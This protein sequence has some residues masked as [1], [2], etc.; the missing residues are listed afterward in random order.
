[1]SSSG[2]LEPTN[3]LPKSLICWLRPLKLAAEFSLIQ[4]DYREYIS[5]NVRQESLKSR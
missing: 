5:N 1:M 4:L 2:I 3:T